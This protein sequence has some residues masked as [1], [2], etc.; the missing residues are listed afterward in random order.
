MTHRNNGNGGEVIVLF[1]RPQRAPTFG[2]RMRTEVALQRMS[3]RVREQARR[4]ANEAAITE[5]ALFIARWRNDAGCC[6]ACERTL[7]REMCRVDVG[8]GL[9]Y[10][11][12]C[13]D[14][15]TEQGRQ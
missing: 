15:E 9:V 4:I 11:M 8:R 7:N 10:C 5:A 12:R 13:P 2:S 6:A 14:E 1:P 3:A